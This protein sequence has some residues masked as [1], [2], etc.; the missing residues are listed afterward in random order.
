M[1]VDTSRL[2]AAFEK[3]DAKSQ[4]ATEKIVRRLVLDIL[5]RVTFYM[6][7][8][9]G[10]ARGGTQVTIGYL[11]AETTGLTD[12]SGSD[13]I[14]AGQETARRIHIGDIAYVSNNVEYVIY[15]EE[16]TDRS[17]PVKM[18]DRALREVA[19]SLR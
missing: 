14:A 15:L 9:T 18:F 3:F 10:R 12:K 13:T 5:R 17:A 11:P 2:N 4:Q 7:V 8:N 16:G 6:P 1:S 19:A